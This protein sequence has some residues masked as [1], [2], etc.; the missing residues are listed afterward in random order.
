MVDA[1]CLLHDGISPGKSFTN[2]NKP[3]LCRLL[4]DFLKGFHFHFNPGKK[5]PFCPLRKAPL[6]LL[7]EALTAALIPKP[8]STP[9]PAIPKVFKAPKAAGTAKAAKG[10]IPP[11][12]RL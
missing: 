1:Y 2:D 10:K 3:P 8:A 6:C 7:L 4:R 12:Y 5:P 9:A 11:F